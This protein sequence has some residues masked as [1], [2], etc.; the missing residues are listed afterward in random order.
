VLLFYV[1]NDILITV[2]LGGIIVRVQFTLR[3]TEC[4]SEN[5]IAKKNKKLHPERMEAQ[6]FCKK[7]GKKTLHKEKK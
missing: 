2:L 6:K 5:Y 4:K 1:F 3:C 7:C